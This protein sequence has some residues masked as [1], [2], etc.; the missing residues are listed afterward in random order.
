MPL[1][2]NYR[3]LPVTSAEIQRELYVTSFG[4]I[5]YDAGEAYPAPGHP[6][7]YDFKW[8]DGR[9]MGDFAVLL[10]EEGRGEFESRAMGRVQWTA[11]EVLILPA[12]EWHR[13]RPLRQWRWT[14][15]WINANGD[16]LHRMRSKGIL[17]RTALIRQL[18]DIT[19]CKLALD[20]VRESASNGNSAL[21]AAYTL[22]VF[23]VALEDREV[24]H[25][26]FQQHTCGNEIVDQARAFVWE[27]CHQ[28]LHVA[29]LA[30]RFAVTRRT[31]ERLF[32]AHHERSIAQEIVWCRLQRAR[33]MLGEG[34]M[35][36]KEIGYATGF[37]GAK[38]LI[39]SFQRF[40]QQTPSAYRSGL[41]VAR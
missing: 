19:P 34:Q 5:T 28:P 35:T 41:R 21:V 17:P 31:L 4:R 6:R 8:S 29:M 12:G 18:R 25:R 22:E 37:G 27:N 7:G 14:E 36:V 23:A 30:E 24:T 1:E 13:Y 26:G 32:A 16:Y 10:V 9:V 11:G 2:N 33:L 40:Y 38:G 20:R 39:R 15:N 3:Y